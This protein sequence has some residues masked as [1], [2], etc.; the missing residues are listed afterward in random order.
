MTPAASRADTLA[1]SWT[2]F[3]SGAT[4]RW[5]RSPMAASLSSIDG[6]DPQDERLAQQSLQRVCG[7]ARN[8]LVAQQAGAVGDRADGKHGS[9]GRR[10]EEDEMCAAVVGVAAAC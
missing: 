1:E 9:A 3:R 6:K 2:A 8:N 4:R 5:S 10:L 7:D